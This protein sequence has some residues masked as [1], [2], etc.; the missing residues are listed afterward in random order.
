MRS[1]HVTSIQY[2]PSRT[3]V[4]L[5]DVSSG[6]ESDYEVR[7]GGQRKNVST[8]TKQDFESATFKQLF[9]HK[10]GAAYLSDTEPDS[11]DD[12]AQTQPESARGLSAT[13]QQLGGGKPSEISVLKNRQRSL[14]ARQNEGINTPTMSEHVSDDTT[15]L[16][17]NKGFRRKWTGFGRG[18][19]D[20]HDKASR[21]ARALRHRAKDV[22]GTALAKKVSGQLEDLQK[23]QLE[24]P[25]SQL[26]DRN[27]QTAKRRGY[28]QAPSTLVTLDNDVS[29]RGEQQPAKEALQT[30]ESDSSVKQ[31]G[32]PYT[33]WDDTTTSAKQKLMFSV[34]SVDAENRRIQSES[35]GNPYV[36]EPL[37]FTRIETATDRSAASFLGGKDDAETT[38]ESQHL[39]DSLSITPGEKRFTTSSYLTQPQKPFSEHVDTLVSN[40]ES[41]QFGRLLR[42]HRQSHSNTNTQVMATLDEHGVRDKRNAWKSVLSRRQNSMLTS[43][44]DAP[45]LKYKKPKQN[46]EEL[47]DQSDKSGDQY[48]RKVKKTKLWQQTS[49]SLD[50]SL[51]RNVQRLAR[52]A[53]RVSREFDEVSQSR[54]KRKREADDVG[55]SPK[56]LARHKSSSPTTTTTTTTTRTTPADTKRA[57]VTR[58]QSSRKK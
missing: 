17:V 52:V 7:F 28:L 26:R 1:V 57:R 56:G 46:L 30:L 54:Q 47:I 39:A 38:N 25:Y 43:G 23:E 6:D 24:V 40:N 33:Y 12:E 16:E 14:I 31:V 27:L 32:V 4:D 49:A 21:R 35:G 8:L 15:S 34:T 20:T 22:G 41:D 19:E 42:G 3:T 37:S 29:P 44:D 58:S 10:P 53:G 11:S 45:Y 48:A 36:P 18:K 5:G 50:Q 51:R 9:P 2:A 13:F 55:Q